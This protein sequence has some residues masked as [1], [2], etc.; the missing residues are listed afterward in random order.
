MRRE[1]YVAAAKTLTHS[2]PEAVEGVSVDAIQLAHHSDG[3]FHYDPYLSLLP[4]LRTHRGTSESSQWL[5]FLF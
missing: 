4:V 3:E 5:F 2:Q 1:V